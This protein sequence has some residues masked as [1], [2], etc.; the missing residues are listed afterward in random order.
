MDR[1]DRRVRAHYEARDDAE[2]LLTPGFGELTRIRTWD[3]FDRVLPSPPALVFDVGGGPGLHSQ[4][5]AG[6]G[7][8]VTLVDPVENNLNLARKRA[9]HGRPFAVIS[10]DA[11]AIPADDSVADVV[12]LM[13]PL[14]HLPNRTDRERALREARRVLRPGGLLLTEVISRFCWLIERTYVDD[15]AD[16]S[17]WREFEEEVTSGMN[18]PEDLV[19]P[20]GFYAYFHRPETAIEEVADAGFESVGAFAVEGYAANIPNLAE[21]LANDAEPILRGLRLVETEPSLLGVSP[22]VL[23]AATRSDANRLG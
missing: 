13:G 22:H 3:L 4:R 16:P 15:V 7:Y 21:R 5:L 10:G 12:L 20:N 9:G 23:I 19:P 6:L 18:A 11:R 14:Y 2:R 17:R 8:D 1:I